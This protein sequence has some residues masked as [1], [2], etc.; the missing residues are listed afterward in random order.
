[1]E[2]GFG[3]QRLFARLE[4]VTAYSSQTKMSS[5]VRVSIGL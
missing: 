3:I 1:M 5:G 4:F 2:I